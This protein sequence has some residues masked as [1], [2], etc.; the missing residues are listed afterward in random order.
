MSSVDVLPFAAAHDLM[1]KSPV[2]QIEA[3]RSGFD[4][5][6]MKETAE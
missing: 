2:T 4:L 5:K 3:Q 1:D 6:R